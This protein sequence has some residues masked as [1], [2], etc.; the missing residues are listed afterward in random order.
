[1][2]SATPPALACADARAVDGVSRFAAQTSTRMHRN[3]YALI[4][5]AQ[6]HIE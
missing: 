1:M 5:I 6:R 4:T 2:A 3:A